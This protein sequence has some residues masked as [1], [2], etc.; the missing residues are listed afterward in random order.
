[1]GSHD[2]SPLLSTLKRAAA[3]LRQA[4]IPFALCGG[5]AAYARGA[6][7]PHHDVDFLILEADVERALDALASIGMRA[8]RPPEDWLVKAWD[9]VEL[10]DGS[11]PDTGARQETLVDLIFRP[12]GRAITPDLLADIEHLEVAAVRMPVI[13]A[14]HLLI[15][16]LLAFS[17]H[18]CDFAEALP[19]ARA[20]REQIDW[21]R[22]RKE[23]AESPYAFAFLVLLEKLGVIAPEELDEP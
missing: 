9:P 5:Y 11:G 15:S 20:L 10:P 18:G 8:E 21:P 4:D 13:S 17:P 2:Q 6:A 19:M 3:A 14:T 16:K 23:T 7:A 12:A 22:V 1:M